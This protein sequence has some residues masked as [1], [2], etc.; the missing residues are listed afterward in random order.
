[1]SVDDMVRSVDL[2]ID[3]IIYFRSQMVDRMKNVKKTSGQCESFKMNFGQDDCN[4][5]FMPT[6]KSIINSM[7]GWLDIYKLLLQEKNVPR[8]KSAKEQNEET[9]F[10]NSGLRI[11]YNYISLSRYFLNNIELLVPYPELGTGKPTDV[12]FQEVR[13]VFATQKQYSDF[14]ATVVKKLLNCEETIGTNI[15]PIFKDRVNPQNY[16]KL[17]AICA[18]QI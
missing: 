15:L 5:S 18:V 8:E 2:V 12:K 17:R 13:N 9:R 16:E 14:I 3:N 4:V 7:L 11:I 6:I 10:Y 1:M